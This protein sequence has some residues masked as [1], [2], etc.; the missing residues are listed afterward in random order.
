MDLTAT[1]SRLNITA[2]NEMQQAMLDTVPHA[3]GTILLSP[4]GSGKTLGFLLP[5][6]TL[7]V[8]AVAGV[9]ALIVVPSRELAIQ[10]EGVYRQMG[11]GYKVNSCYGG[12]SVRTEENNFSQ[13][14]AVLIGTPG[15][16][17]HHIRAQ[18]I[19]LSNTHT[20]VMDEFDKSLELGFQED[21]SFI[22]SVLPALRRRILTSATALDRIPSFLHLRE[23]KVLD[24][25][26]MNTSSS[27]LALRS[28]HI[29]E[30]LTRPEG[31]ALLL[32]KLRGESAI[33]FC[34]HRDAVK[35]VGVQLRSM[36]IAHGIYHG[37]MEQAD[38]EKALIM[39]RNGSTNILVTTD[40]ASRGLDIPE[41]RHIIHYQ[42]PVSAQAFIHRNGRT[43]RM[44]ADGTAYLLLEAKDH[45]PTFISQEVTEENL[46]DHFTALPEP[47]WSTLYIAAGKKD[48]INKTDVVGLLLQKGGLQ[49]EEVG[50]IEVLDKAAYVAVRSDKISKTLRTISEHKI[51]GKKVRYAVAD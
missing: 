27:V 36:N 20:L 17:A 23:P 49:R 30:D 32:S 21:M 44:H 46:P 35:R 8:P 38:R 51:K 39:L 28:V 37:E 4:T 18:N 40:L 1:L 48:K 42:L 9:Q 50:R 19:D 11:T 26:H 34:N 31:L 2:L 7:L 47:Q 14:P 45:I 3:E 29:P 24:F 22:V 41:I 25:T 6:A 13:P 5:V 16:I 43:A 12:H 15:R 10:I 33:I